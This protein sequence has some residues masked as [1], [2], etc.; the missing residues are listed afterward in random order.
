MAWYEYSRFRC[1]D[2][3]LHFSVGVI[4]LAYLYNNQSYVAYPG[5]SNVIYDPLRNN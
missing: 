4:E 5:N 1:I 2:G 3:L